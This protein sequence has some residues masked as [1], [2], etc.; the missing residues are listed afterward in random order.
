MSGVVKEFGDQISRGGRA[1]ANGI[2]PVSVVR[3]GV[4]P[5][6]IAGVCA[7]LLLLFLGVSVTGTMTM[8]VCTKDT[9]TSEEVCVPKQVSRK[10]NI[11]W[12]VIGI[13]M[14]SLI[15]G[16]LAYK[17]GFMINN[18]KITAGVAAGN[19]VAGIFK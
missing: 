16:G 7:L 17:L 5:G 6:S 9:P 8:N 2:T 3:W 14:A 4:I 12:Y 15:V 19:L 13:P 18:Q 1:I 10:Y 11:L